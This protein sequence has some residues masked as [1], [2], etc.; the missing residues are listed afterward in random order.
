MASAWETEYSTE[1]RRTTSQ[2][3]TSV[4]PDHRQGSP[5]GWNGL[6]QHA[7][8]ATDLLIT[9]VAMTIKAVTIT[10][11]VTII[12]AITTKVQAM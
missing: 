6:E 11:V 2:K 3:A 1:E 5:R 4:M 9:K 10:K 7:K 12:K 8:L